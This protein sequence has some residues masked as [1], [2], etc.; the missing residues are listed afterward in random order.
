MIKYIGASMHY[1]INRW[2]SWHSLLVDLVYNYK[3]IHKD[4]TIYEYTY[5]VP[6]ETWDQMISYFAA[7]H[8]LYPSNLLNTTIEDKF[9]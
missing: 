2:F 4:S 7:G 3:T 9:I 1:D 6:T 8:H 5:H